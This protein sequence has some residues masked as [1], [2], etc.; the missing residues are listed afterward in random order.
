MSAEA[1]Q[2]KV[3]R[4]KAQIGQGLYHVDARAVAY[5]ILLYERRNHRLVSMTGDTPVQ[6]RQVERRSP[7]C[8]RQGRSERRPSMISP[9]QGRKLR[10]CRNGN[11]RALLF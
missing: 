2:A 3:S 5:A 10:L 11:P 9:L 8:C 6:M 1:R 7:S 4:L